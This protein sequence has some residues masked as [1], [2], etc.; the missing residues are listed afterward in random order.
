M[1]INILAIAAHPDDVE[2]S[3]AGTL[4]VHQKKGFTTGIIDLTQGEM[5]T[6]G[7]P[8]MRL[9]EAEASAEILKLSVRKNLNLGDSFFENNKEN[10]LII[11]KEIRAYQPDM[12]LTNAKFDR[13]P[14]HGRGAELVT[15]A[16]F[17]AGLKKIETKDDEGNPQKP[18]RPKKVYHAIQSTAVMPDFL[19]DISD[20][21][22]KKMESIKAYQSQ[23]FDP[24]SKEPETYIS[25][26]EFLDMITS[27]AQ[28]F[29][30]RI[31]VKYAEGFTTDQPLGVKDLYHLI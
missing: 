4:M 27:R 20:V 22:D 9:K 23:F 29:G 14:D 28:E 5:G 31:Q 15:Q 13:H 16:C 8:E 11:A 12:V 7:T 21:M 2:L 10:Q 17:L 18:W 19:V 6:R 25:R 30:H 1:K 3:C 24:N 26:P